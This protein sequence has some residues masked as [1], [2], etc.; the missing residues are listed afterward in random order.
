MKPSCAVTKLTDAQAGRPCRSKRSA[1]PASRAAKSAR[2]P[3]SPRQKRRTVVAEAVVPFGEAGRKIA[4]LVA[5]R[6]DV[7]RLG[8]QLHAAPA[9]DPGA[10]ASKKPAPGSKPCGSRPSVAPRSKRKPSTWNAC[11]PVAQRVH[12]HLQHARMREVQRVA[13]AGVVDVVARVVGHQPVV[14]GVVE[15]AERQRRAESRCPRRCG[16]RRRRGSPRCRP[17]AAGGS[18]LRISLRRCRRT[19]SAAR[20]RRSR[21]CC[22]PSSCAGRA[23]AAGAVLQEGVHRHQLDRGDAESAQVIDDGRDGPARRRCRA[24]LGGCRRAAWSGPCTCAS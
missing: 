15:A 2:C 4:E 21:S 16:C 19:G 11:H 12:H 3:Q 8:D 23:A 5:A 6:T 22:S 18:R 9:P 24:R 1:E 14:A 10:C 20:A 17:H 13:G 7:P